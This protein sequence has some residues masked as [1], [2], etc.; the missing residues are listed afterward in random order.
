MTFKMGKYYKFDDGRTINHYHIIGKLATTCNGVALIAEN[1]AGA[2]CAVKPEMMYSGWAEITE[3]DW[4]SLFDPKPAKQP[5]E[6]QALDDHRSMF[7][8]RYY[9]GEMCGDCQFNR[10]EGPHPAGCSVTKTIDCPALPDDL[11][12]EDH[13]STA[14]YNSELVRMLS[15][16]PGN[17]RVVTPGFDEAGFEDLAQPKLELVV[18]RDDIELGGHSG[19]HDGAKT[20]RKTD[21]DAHAVAVINLI[22]ADNG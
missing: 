3:D 15:Q 8:D 12:S 20:A 17:M 7:I 21:P 2:L 11:L 18:L 14:M 4:R 5:T 9:A 22:F 6:P 16:Y 13:S 1:S 19:R 10:F